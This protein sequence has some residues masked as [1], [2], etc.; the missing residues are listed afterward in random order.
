LE[1]SPGTKI[2]GQLCGVSLDAATYEQG[3]TFIQ[4][5]FERAGEDSLVRLWKSARELPTPAEL[6]APG[7]W[8]ARIEIPDDPGPS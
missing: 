8:L 1:E 6:S 2:L 5:V 3:Q 7:L 4:G